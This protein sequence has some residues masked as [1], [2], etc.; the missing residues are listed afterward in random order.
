MVFKIVYTAKPS[1]F[2]RMFRQNQTYQ[3]R[4]VS[5]NC[6]AQLETPKTEMFKK[7]FRHNGVILWNS[8]PAELRKMSNLIEFKVNLKKWIIAN[9]PIQ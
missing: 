6:L 8:L 4:Q 5:N 9:I 3:T 2:S 1:Y 7:S